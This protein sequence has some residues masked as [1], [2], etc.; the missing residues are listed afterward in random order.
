MAGTHRFS[1]IRIL[2]SLL[3]SLEHGVNEKK[4]AACTATCAVG[5]TGKLFPSKRGAAQLPQENSPWAVASSPNV[6]RPGGGCPR[7]RF[8]GGPMLSF[9]WE[10]LR[11]VSSRQKD[12]CAKQEGGQSFALCS[13][14]ASCCPRDPSHS[15]NRVQ[16]PC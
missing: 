12:T 16:S 9:A 14:Q 11:E 2:A 6:G 5:C 1:V 15:S 3:V 10:F 7:L 4:T 13:S 8:F